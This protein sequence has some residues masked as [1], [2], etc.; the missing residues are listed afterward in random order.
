MKIITS[1]NYDYDYDYDY[2]SDYNTNNDSNSSDSSEEYSD[3]KFRLVGAKLQPPPHDIEQVEIIS[4]SQQQKI[5][6]ISSFSSSSSI[7]NSY[8]II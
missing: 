4:G 5:R 6:T 2:D 8:K 3:N 1:T 7:N